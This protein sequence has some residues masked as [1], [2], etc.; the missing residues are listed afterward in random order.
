MFTSLNYSTTTAD[1]IQ[2]RVMI[3]W[4]PLPKGTWVKLRPLTDTHKEILDYRA[5]LEAHLRQHYNTL[6]MGQTL[7]CKYGSKQYPFLVIDLKP[8]QAVGVNDTDLEVD[9]EPYQPI[10]N[11]NNIEQQHDYSSNSPITTH[12]NAN[13]N[14]TIQQINLDQPVEQIL[15]KKNDYHYWSMAI[16]N[17]D[18]LLVSMDIINGNA[19]LVI[20]YEAYPKIDNYVWGDLTSDKQKRLRIEKPTKKTIYIGI[21]GYIDSAVSLVITSSL[22]SFS[23]SITNKKENEKESKIG[24][25]QC[26]NCHSWVSET[27]FPLH[28]TFCL[29]NN[30]LCPWGC[31][32]VF[33]RN[34]SNALEQHWHCE[35]CDVIG[36]GQLENEK[37]KHQEYY[38]SQ[39]TCDQCHHHQQHESVF[40]SLLQ[41]AHH[42]QTVCSGRL[43]ICRY[44]H[45]SVIQGPMATDA[46][47][48]LIGLHEHE[49]YC[50]SRTIT[51][52]KCQKS[53]PIKEI[54][55]HAKIHEV[56]RQN[57]KLP[58]LCNNQQC[59]RPKSN[60]KL[61]LCQYCFGPF[62]VTEDDPKHIKLIQRVARKIHTQLT[63]GC[64]NSWCQNKLCATG[65]NSPQD[66]TTAAS[67]LIPIIQKLTIQLQLTSP[68]PVLNLCVDQKVT[69]LKFLAETL[70]EENASYHLDW[71]VKALESEQED[72]DRAKN[73][74]QMNAPRRK[75]VK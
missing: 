8:E 65:S 55:V 23:S 14:T 28:E 2:Q 75:L 27:T 67:T 18:S 6:T 72:L 17:S 58:P 51:C 53:I 4:K 37:I 33:Q 25:V 73:W 57:Q 22:P 60:N 45:T 11:D 39:Y 71:C 46:R 15:I 36:N 1:D 29:R 7:T 12:L 35:Q 68:K 38:H 63:H 61:G 74:L 31:G 47:D 3:Q 16:S 64:G 54:P 59:I 41:L 19:D 10:V 48:K 62:W 30:Q 66:A 44:C 70:M 42:K 43:I 9:L 24:Q 26:Q 21:Y 40:P 32:Q 52:Q 34:N 56:A 13:I 49:S 5:A 69:R 50:G 20:G